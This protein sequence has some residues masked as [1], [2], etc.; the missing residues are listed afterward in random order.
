MP[1]DFGNQAKTAEPKKEHFIVNSEFGP[2][3]CVPGDETAKEKKEL[4][5]I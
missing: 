1:S 2:S 5:K 3:K 4:K